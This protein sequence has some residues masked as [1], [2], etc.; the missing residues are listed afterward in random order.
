[1]AR[2]NVICLVIILSVSIVFPVSAARRMA[3]V[4]INLAPADNFV[5]IP[6]I[7]KETAENIVN[8]RKTQG[9]FNSLQDLM[10]V[11]GIDRELFEQIELYL[12]ITLP[13]DIRVDELYEKLEQLQEKESVDEID[14]DF[15]DL[16]KYRFNP[17]DIN[18]ASYSQLM[19]LPY[20]T[21]EYAQAIIDY[22]RKN[23]GFEY[24]DDLKEVIPYYIY[25]LIFPFITV[26][27]GKETE[28][29][30]GD[31]RFRYGVWPY[32]FSESYFESDPLYQHPE[33]FYG[34]Y[35]MYYGNKTE[36]GLVLRKDRYS[37]DLDY[38]N[39]RNYYLIKKYMVLRNTFGFDT[40]VLGNYSLDFAQGMFIQPGPFLARSIPRKPKGL[41][42]DKGTHIN[43]MFYGIAF[44]KEVSNLDLYGFYSDKPIIVNYL[45]EDGSVGTP[46]TVFYDYYATYLT[47]DNSYD[48]YGALKERLVGARMD[49]DLTAFLN[50]GGGY[51]EEEFDPYIDPAQLAYAGGGN[52]E[53]VY[54]L[55]DYYFRGDRVNLVS[56][57]ME[58]RF[59]NFRLL[60]DWGRSYYH[61]FKR[62]ERMEDEYLNKAKDWFWDEGDGYEVLGIIDYQKVTFYAQYHWLDNDYFAFHSSPLMTQLGVETFIRD[63][64]GYGVGSKFRAGPVTTQINVN[65]GHPIVPVRY[66]STQVDDLVSWAAQDEYEIYLDNSW[67]ALEGFTVGYRNTY[68]INSR[69]LAY[70][71]PSWLSSMFD[72]DDFSVY[73]PYR[74]MKNRFEL[75]HEPSDSVRLK[76]RYEVIDNTYPEIKVEMSGYST[77][78]ELK[79]KPTSALTIFARVTYWDAPRGVSAGAM[80]YT[81]P[82]ALIPYSYYSVYGATEKGFRYYLMPT[83]K[84]SKNAKLWTKYEFWPDPGGAAKNVFKLQYD[85]SW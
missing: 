67:S 38:E 72:G 31:L 75:V 56:G 45:N 81:W 10:K 53:H 43:D 46:P 76:W 28:N 11:E 4:D 40:I 51:Y 42:E 5:Q 9:F 65:Y 69:T 80:E 48:Y 18:T 82:N 66:Y 23:K 68:R 33:Y 78:G 74:S 25:E 83:L 19:D 21:G 34:R 13:Q 71:E 2:A 49:Y 77:F 20:M 39:I 84:F 79:Y 26:Y 7:T 85:F 27:K 73:M 47:G 41:K 64:E 70:G 60:F 17:L 59:R 35:R 36:L 16:D 37:R 44:K 55:S 29:F 52:Y 1:M 22:R 61:S 30:H 54:L 62:T 24:I 32:P 58:Y 14:L 57:N 12:T 6:G 3:L 8:Y 63:E 50:L 15:D